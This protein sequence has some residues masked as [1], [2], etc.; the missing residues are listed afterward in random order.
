MGGL[1]PPRPTPGYATESYRVCEYII[2]Q[3][4]KKEE[5][6]WTIKLRNSF[7]QQQKF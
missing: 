3:R 1:E 7:L 5:I 2:L 4:K 6:L